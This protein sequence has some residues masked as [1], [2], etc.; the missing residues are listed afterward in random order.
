VDGDGT[1]VGPVDEAGDIISYQVVVTNTGN[2]TLTGVTLSD[3]LVLLVGSPTE[4]IS[5]NGDLDVGENWT[6]TYTYT[7]T[8]QDLEDNWVALGGTGDGYIDNTATADSDQLDPISDSERVPVAQPLWAFTPGF[9][10]NHTSDASSGHDAWVYTDYCPYDLVGD[11]FSNTG[12]YASDTLLDALGYPGGSGV[13]GAMRN[14]LRHGVAS[15][16]NAS[17]HE[18]MGNPIGEFGVYPYDTSEIIDMVSSA[19]GSGDRTT[20]LDLASELD[21]YNN[22]GIHYI[23]WEWEPFKDPCGGSSSSIQGSTEEA[24]AIIAAPLYIFG[25]VAA[26]PGTT[27]ELWTT[28][29][30][31]T[32]VASATVD[33]TYYY[34][35]NNVD[36]GEYTVRSLGISVTIYLS[37]GPFVNVD[38]S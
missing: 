19:L 12:P 33:G 13:E 36:A 9:W 5:A 31:P 37:E 28:G 35:F 1:G 38:F 15:L 10:K 25:R 23:D 14:L 8:Q 27:V 34:W 7:V 4:S 11:I 24:P 3:T 26:G 6:W 22:E 21:G 30:N 2:Q 29:E 32:L 16:L 20:M 18:S 17:F